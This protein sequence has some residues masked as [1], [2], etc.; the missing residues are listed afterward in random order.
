MAR[1]YSKF[2]VKG[3]G[4]NLNRKPI[5][6]IARQIGLIKCQ[7]VSLLYFFILLSFKLYLNLLIPPQS[8]KQSEPLLKRQKGL[9]S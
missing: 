1:D 9:Q 4:E 8:F 6:P 7:K 5:I 2:K 3:L